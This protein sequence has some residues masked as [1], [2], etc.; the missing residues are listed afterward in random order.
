M[1][2]V[3]INKYN[4]VYFSAEYPLFLIRLSVSST[5]MPIFSSLFRHFFD[6]F[7]SKTPYN[8]P[9]RKVHLSAEYPLLAGKYHWAWL[10]RKLRELLCFLDSLYHTLGLFC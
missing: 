8:S 1:Y 2:L 9:H 4:K 3:L 10:K 6:L 5:V 7:S